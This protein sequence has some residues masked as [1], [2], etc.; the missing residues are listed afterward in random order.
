M[1]GRQVCMQLPALGMF[2]THMYV[3]M[4]SRG[5]DEEAH[6]FLCR[7]PVL[8]PQQD[9]LICLFQGGQQTKSILCRAP[10]WQSMHAGYALLYAANGL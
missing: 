9:F 1:H 5:E 4:T 7:T 8:S 10:K 6:P 2:N 3:I